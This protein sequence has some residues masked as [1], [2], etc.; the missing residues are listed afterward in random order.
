VRECETCQQNKSKQTHPT[1]LLHPLPIPE[2]K[3]EIISMDFITG[4]PKVK[5]V[6]CIYVVVDRL[7]KF[8]HFFPH[9][10]NIRQHK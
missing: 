10:Q 4:F 5:G 1:G 8:S 9:I 6:D 3:W 7:T 2:Q